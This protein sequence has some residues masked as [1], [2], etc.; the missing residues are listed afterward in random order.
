MPADADLRGAEAAQHSGPLLTTV[1]L[2]DSSSVE[3][4]AQH[5]GPL[6]TK[7]WPVAPGGAA[8]TPLLRPAPL[9]PPP[10][11]PPLGLPPPL[12]PQTPPPT[13][14]TSAAA[15]LRRALQQ[16][17]RETQATSIRYILYLFSGMHR[18]TPDTFLH[19]VK[20]I[21]LELGMQVEVVEF[22]TLNGSTFDLSDEMTWGQI[23][24]DIRSMKYI[25]ALLSPPCGTFGCRRWD[26][27]G[28]PPLRGEAG[29][30]LYGLPGL[31]ADDLANVKLGTLLA[32]RACEA[33]D[34][35]S[36]AG[37]PWICEQPAKAKG[38]AHM[39]AL[40]EWELVHQRHGATDIIVPQCSFGADYLKPT[41]FKYWGCSP[42]PVD[43]VC[44]H[45]KRSWR[46]V[47]SG[48]RFAA[49]H[50]PLR[51]KIPPVLE[52]DWTQALRHKRAPAGAAFLTAAAATYPAKLNSWLAATLIHAVPNHAAP[53]PTGGS[54]M[55]RV[56][57]FNNVLVRADTVRAPVAVHDILATQQQIESGVS[58]RGTAL[59]S[60]KR[61]RVA[62]GQAIGGMRNPL[63]SQAFLPGLKPVGIRV[64]ETLVRCLHTIPG[65]MQ[66]CLEA[67]GSDV[68]NA[69]PTE[70][71]I[72]C[73]RKA[74]EAVF[75][76]VPPT[77]ANPDL[78]TVVD[79]NLM[80]AWTVTAGD[81]DLQVVSWLEN[82]APAGLD[83][84]IPQCGIFPPSEVDPLHSSHLLWHD[85][86][87]WIPVQQSA[88]NRKLVDEAM[89]EMIADSRVKSFSS[90]RDVCDF[91]GGPAVLSKVHVLTKERIT[92]TGARVVKKRTIVDT[93]A[94]NVS[95]CTKLPERTGAA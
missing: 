50:P 65:L 77:A 37:L 60:A 66:A 24:S 73:C 67:L 72:T 89:D 81:P 64:K 16:D 15:F 11:P 84:D 62:D 5:S 13:P 58:L 33:A 45:P 70:A 54:S 1:P 14:A 95:M 59:Q 82:G 88:V 22:D 40:K 36:K 48:R 27:F 39:F 38:R 17:R 75:G 3:A 86:L 8:G 30:D 31:S 63:R 69:G 41:V 42:T 23:L 79:V 56:G 90:W 32:L 57:R 29:A 87:D 10:L 26:S 85:E 20:Q 28:P 71:Q 25:A 12:P 47:P 53:A 52:A 74:L 44:I 55:V 6:L 19:Y 83:M 21:S 92:A 46:E 94:S 68:A 49:S 18:D 34:L 9:E 91:V 7:H 4:P 35:F 78:P 76:H 61:A 2:A 51:G 43:L 93:K 80:R